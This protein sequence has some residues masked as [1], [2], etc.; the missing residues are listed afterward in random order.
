MKIQIELEK[1]EIETLLNLVENNIEE[2]FYYGNKKFYFKRI[3]KIKNEL[4]K[5]LD[6]REKEDT[7]NTIKTPSQTP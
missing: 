4:I 3:E 1:I 2:G 6:L 7:L 5:Q